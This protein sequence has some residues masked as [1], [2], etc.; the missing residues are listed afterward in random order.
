MDSVIPARFRL[1]QTYYDPDKPPQHYPVFIKPEWG[2]NSN[3]IA[4]VHNEKE[5]QAFQKDI[6]VTGMPFIVQDAA[7]EKKEFEIYYLRSP[8]NSDNCA[9]LSITEVTNTC[10]NH[11]PINSIHNSCTGYR[12]ITQTFSSNELQAIWFS[13]RN[14][15]RFRMA[16]V[17]LKAADPRGILREEFHIV[18]INLFLPMPLVLLTKNVGLFEKNMIMKKVMS[19][20]ARLAKTIP[21]KE[22]GKTIFL[23]KFIVDPIMPHQIIPQGKETQ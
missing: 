20:A 7:T 3:G 16:R 14:I 9:F 13:L 21:E 8:D 18:E 4:R 22:S 6:D 10:R 19:L 17:G 11:H 12:D 2:Q 23:Q 1:R 15:G 5:Y